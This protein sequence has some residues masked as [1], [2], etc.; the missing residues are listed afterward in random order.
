MSLVSKVIQVGVPPPSFSEH[1]SILVHF[2]DFKELSSKKGSYEQSSSFKLFNHKW[3]VVLYPGG[4]SDASDDMVSIGL[5]LYSKGNIEV[6]YWFIVRDASGELIEKTIRHKATFD[7]EK[8]WSYNV[9][10]VSR[11]TVLEKAL[12]SGTLTIELQ[13]IPVF[14]SKSKYCKHFIPANCAIRQVISDKPDSII[15]SLLFDEESADICFDVSSSSDDTKPSV[16]VYAHKA[17]LKA[18]TPDLAR[19]CTG[20]DVSNSMPISDVEP[21]IF[22]EVMR[23]IY[24]S[25]MDSTDWKEDAKAIL[26]ATNKYDVANLK[27][28]AEAWYVTYLE[29]TAENVADQLLY[30]DAMSCPLLKEAAVNFMVDNGVDVFSSDSF[31]TVLEARGITLQILQTMAKKLD[32]SSVAAGTD[33]MSIND[34]R[35]RLSAY[36]FA[37]DGD[38]EILVRRFVDLVKSI[39]EAEEEQDQSTT[40]DD[41]NND[42]EADDDGDDRSN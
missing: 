4:D 9:D 16:K 5:G 31:K 11:S 18:R 24:G 12:Y 22:R 33:S 2:H 34:L 29:F 6:K 23:F 15:S 17:I 8:N 1:R 19:L 38:R 26:E 32:S 39:D 42:A 27:V 28:T 3:D 30:A 37:V 41:Q 14:D 40:T 35:S 7:T 21:D 25:C 13:M 36:R 10:L 20:Y